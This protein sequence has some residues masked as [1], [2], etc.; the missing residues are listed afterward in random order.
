M[1]T[2][3]PSD[4]V[5]RTEACDDTVD[6]GHIEKVALS[7][8]AEAPRAGGELPLLWHWALFVK[9]APYGQL[10]DDGHPQR[11]GF[12][13]AADNRNRMWAGGRLEFR[14]PLR[15]GTP[16]KRASTIAAVKEK[17]GRSGKLLFV[18]VKHEYSQDGVSCIAEEQ[19][20]VYREPSPPKLEGSTPAPRAQWSETVAPSSVMLFRYSAVTFNGH[21]I[22]YDEPYVT[23]TEGYPGLVVHGPLIATL[24]CRAF[25][26]A[27]PD[28]A[29][30]SFSYRGLRPLIAPRPFQ[31]AGALADDHGAQLWAEQDGML[32]HQAELRFK[33]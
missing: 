33:P 22:H 13:P 2:M 27:H 1:T 11:G 20:I 12:L 17:E 3:N 32:A 5:G 16:G 6:I 31:V 23:Q 21:R 15:V 30:T 19:D 7:L 26:R 29:V 24:M 10:G 8:D 28:K 4:W 14:H 9:G 25:S 18:T